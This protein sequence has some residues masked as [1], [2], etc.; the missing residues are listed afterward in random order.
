VQLFTAVKLPRGFM[1]AV[2]TLSTA[3]LA[4]LLVM[5]TV[6][7]GD[8]VPASAVPKLIVPVGVI[9]AEACTAVPLRVRTWRLCGA[10]SEIINRP[11]R[12]PVCVGS[13]VTFIT[14]V[15]PPAKG[16]CEQL[17]VSAKSPGFVPPVLIVIV[18]AVVP[19]LLTVTGC[20]ALLAPTVCDA[21]F[22]VTGD[23]EIPDVPPLPLSATVC[24]LPPAL[25]E[26][27]SVA[28]TGPAA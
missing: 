28:L 19:V 3:G 6:T 2:P 8:A 1:L 18:T 13:K 23:N 4:P 24:G 22:K 5:V 14:Q 12:L 10:L 17:S 15:L 9:V 16:L 27:L 26:M 11:E 21:K 7:G 25:S 20:A